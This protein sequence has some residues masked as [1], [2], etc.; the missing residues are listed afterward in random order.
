MNKCTGG[1][2]VSCVLPLLLS[3]SAAPDRQRNVGGG[4][5]EGGGGE[6]GVHEG[7]LLHPLLPT[8]HPGAS[9]MLEKTIGE[10]IVLFNV[11]LIYSYTKLPF[12][13]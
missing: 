2:T 8:M 6:D 9:G 1:S 3:E 4:G 13:K 7:E 11:A 12:Q 5:S 10:V